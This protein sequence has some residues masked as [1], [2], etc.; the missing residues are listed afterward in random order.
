M[1]SI[2]KAGL[3]SISPDAK[4]VGKSKNKVTNNCIVIEVR[5]V[6]YLLAKKSLLITLEVP[7]EA[8]IHV[9]IPTVGIQSCEHVDPKPNPEVSVKR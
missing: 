3:L 9:N 8:P 6:G 1:S 2:V 7:Q 5:M 4:D